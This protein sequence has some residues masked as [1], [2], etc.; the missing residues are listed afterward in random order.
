[1]KVGSISSQP[2]LGA[3]AGA[4]ETMP[5]GSRL[6]VKTVPGVGQR[7]WDGQ[8]VNLEVTR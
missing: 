6:V 2:A 8:A 4:P 3:D 5:A 7:V 1:M